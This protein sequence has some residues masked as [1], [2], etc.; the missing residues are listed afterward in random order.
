[1][2]KIGMGKIGILAMGIALLMLFAMPSALAG[3]SVTVVTPAAAANWSG[4]QTITW[5]NE[6]SNYSATTYY[7]LYSATGASPWTYCA[8]GA[9]LSNTTASLSWATADLTA[10]TAYKV[11][12][13]KVNATTNISGESG[14][15][16]VDNTAPVVAITGSSEG[17]SA[18]Q[19]HIY[20][21]ETNITLSGTMTDAH[22]GN[23]NLTAGTTAATV[24][25]TTWSITTLP[26]A[27]GCT[28]VTATGYDGAS[29]A[30]TD[31][32]TICRTAQRNGSWMPTATPAYYQP[33]AEGLQTLTIIPEEGLP[34]AVKK[35]G[36]LAV[37]AIVIFL[38]W[39]Q[40]GSKPNRKRRR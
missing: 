38:V 39:R 30:G 12:V 22:A 29:N 37:I 25:A 34:D 28:L 26:V 9:A 40:S 21:I 10:G 8:D 36:V 33:P 18:G 13:T 11:N 14:T 20:T 32:I 19:T 6:S 5:T 17:I 23:T 35:V 27:T 31:T 24:T 3:D 15:F 7:V 4:T 2:K 1:M 16:T